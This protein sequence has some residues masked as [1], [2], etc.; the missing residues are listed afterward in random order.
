MTI[1]NMSDTSLNHADSWYKK[2]LF[3]KYGN[4]QVFFRE[5]VTQAPED[6]LSTVQKPVLLLLHG[7]PTCSWDFAAIWPQL[8]NSFRLVTLDFLGFGCSDKPNTG[9][10]ISLQADITQALLKHL[11]IDRFH[12]LSH[13]F[14]D[15]VAIEL[16]ARMQSKGDIQSLILTN[17]GIFADFHQPLLIQKLLA[18]ALGK[19]IA[20]LIGFKHFKKSM[21][22]IFSVPLNESQL[23]Q[24]WQL[25]NLQ[26]GKRV[27]PQL[28]KYMNERKTYQQ[29]WEG[30]LE[31]TSVPTG[32]IAGDDDPISGSQM[33]ARYRQ[34]KPQTTA[35]AMAETGHYPH[36]ERPSEFIRHLFNLYQCLNIDISAS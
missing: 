14:G 22:S 5:N 18:S 1:N 26:Q 27:F 25:L 29:R 16:V 28:I 19:I 36:V 7:F 17:G 6:T 2:G 10:S 3:F 12:I 32:L 31:A 20:P 34:I 15:T 24:Y 13:D 23:E 4:D 9:Y 8:S 30:T 33:I 21:E 35:I 11:N